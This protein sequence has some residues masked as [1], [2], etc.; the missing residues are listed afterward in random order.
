MMLFPHICSFLISSF[1]NI[2]KKTADVRIAPYLLSLILP[3]IILRTQRLYDLPVAFYSIVLLAHCDQFMDRMSLPGKFLLVLSHNIPSAE[4]RIIVKIIGLRQKYPAC[5]LHLL[6][7]KIKQLSVVC[8]KFND[9]V[10]GK[11]LVIPL[12]KLLGSKSALCMTCFR[13]RI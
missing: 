1:Y 9:S 3:G 4:C 11:D 12:K 8:L 13:P 6:Q 5:Q 7:L 10:K 2:C